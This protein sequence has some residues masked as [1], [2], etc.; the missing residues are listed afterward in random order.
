MHTE[1]SI[2][3]ADPVIFDKRKARNGK[4]RWDKVKELGN[5]AILSHAQQSSIDLRP[6]SRAMTKYTITMEALDFAK[7][8]ID[9]PAGC[10]IGC[11]DSRTTWRQN[12]SH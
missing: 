11:R 6:P 9:D 5:H 8:Y 10:Q 12:F 4:W 2:L 3:F 7:A 1:G